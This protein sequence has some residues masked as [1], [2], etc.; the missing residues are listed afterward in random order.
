MS[1]PSATVRGPPPG[2]GGGTAQGIGGRRPGLLVSG[3]PPE[4]HQRMLEYML[5]T[6]NNSAEIK[7][8]VFSQTKEMAY[9]E[10]TDPSGRLNN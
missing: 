7:H 2:G 3:I 10:L 1:V 8:V 9:I 5:Y 4:C 6:A